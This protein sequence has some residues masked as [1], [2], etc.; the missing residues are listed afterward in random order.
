[1]RLAAELHNR[2]VQVWVDCLPD[3]LKV[4][5]DWPRGL[6]EAIDTC[7]F[8]IAV[9]SPSYL[10]SWMGQNEL[11]RALQ[12]GQ[13]VLPVLIERVEK[14]P[15][16]LQRVQ[17][18]DFTGWRDHAAFASA[19]TSLV[20][21][22]QSDLR[23]VIGQRPDREQQYL[24]SLIADL[25]SRVGVARY[26]A[27]ATELRELTKGDDRGGPVE[28][29]DWRMD[30]E[31]HLLD[32]DTPLEVE[33]QK[34]RKVSLEEL[35]DR[36]HCFVITGAP[37][38]GKT[39]TLLNIALRLARARLRE[40]RSHPLPVCL[41]LPEWSREATPIDF[42]AARWPIDGNPQVAIESDDVVFLFDGLNEMG[43]AGR[44]NA[45]A[46]RAWIQGPGGP[47]RAVFACR[48]RDYSELHLG[49]D[50][51]EIQPMDAAQIESFA[52]AHLEEQADAFLQRILPPAWT[53][54]DP[55][56]LHALARNPYLLF[57]LLRLYRDRQE[58]PRNMGRLFHRLPGFLWNKERMH[59]TPDWVSFEEARPKL[60]AL[61]FEMTEANESTRIPDGLA[62][63]HL[64]RSF[65]RQTALGA[66]ILDQNETELRFFHHR[67][68]EYFAATELVGQGLD[69]LAGRCDGRWSEVVIAAA[70]LTS[71]SD[72]MVE[73][74]RRQSALLA[75]ECLLSGV[76]VS[77]D[78]A[79]RIEKE[80]SDR[81]D[82]VGPQVVEKEKQR[83][84]PQSY[85]MI[86]DRVGDY[87]A[88]YD[89]LEDLVRK[90]R[91]GER[92]VAE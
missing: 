10:Q 80:L 91:S 73:A 46:L 39:T 54:F 17:Y 65:P 50:K 27:L 18:A 38:A 37:G 76:D 83:S 92:F 86:E 26:I 82:R 88:S 23:D 40:P 75:A 29:D 30:P 33:E 3:G 48:N 89:S 1:L 55:N 15:L 45:G 81:L 5:D 52:R 53:S 42:V 19:A 20:Q 74:V 9:I 72:A 51:A 4:G 71:E 77:A 56:S 90:V 36:P 13:P 60:A 24:L 8:M 14:W 44:A 28:R 67:L 87:F 59:H 62:A 25:E 69:A 68:Q 61:A 16:V 6:E 63:K 43:H 47:R 66:N 70:G 31:F 41:R 7:R 21:R 78:L 79:Q 57:S 35:I 84:S 49:I 58:L 64:G 34:P 2:G 85:M 12:Q 11:N 22:I 32:P